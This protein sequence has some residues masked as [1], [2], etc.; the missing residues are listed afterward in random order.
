MRAR[1]SL[2]CNNKAQQQQLEIQPRNSRGDKKDDVIGEKVAMNGPCQWTSDFMMDLLTV[3]RLMCK[4]KKPFVCDQC[5]EAFAEESQI[6]AH[7]L[8]HHIDQNALSHKG[9]TV[10][11]PKNNESSDDLTFLENLFL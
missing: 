9:K 5:G 10:E 8:I 7:R 6:V 11:P 2:N 3:H 4:D 1:H